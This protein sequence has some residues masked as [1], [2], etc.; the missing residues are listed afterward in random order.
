MPNYS[1][2]LYSRTKWVL[3]YLYSGARQSLEPAYNSTYTLEYW[4]G[5]DG[6]SKY[7]FIMSIISMHILSKVYNLFM[8]SKIETTNSQIHKFKILQKGQ[9]AYWNPCIM[10]NILFLIHYFKKHFKPCF[11]I[12][13]ALKDI[14]QH[15]KFVKWRLWLV[16]INYYIYCHFL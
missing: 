2:H 14:L 1:M 7:L 9:R 4:L 6:L 16:I 15:F 13:K 12:L 5:L 10:V 11:F 8:T 3:E